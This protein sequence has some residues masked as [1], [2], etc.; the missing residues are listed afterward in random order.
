VLAKVAGGG[1]GAGLE[2]LQIN[3]KSLLLAEERYY[4]IL[5]SVYNKCTNDK[6]WTR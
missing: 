4:T 6:Y 3:F 2:E 5:W 1:C